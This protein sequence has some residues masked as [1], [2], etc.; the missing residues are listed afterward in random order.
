MAIVC[1]LVSMSDSLFSNLSYSEAWTVS[2]APLDLHDPRILAMAAAERH[3]LE[4]EYDEYADTNAS[5]AA[6]CRSAAL[7]VRQLLRENHLLAVLLTWKTEL[8]AYS[9]G[10]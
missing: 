9:Y 7:I 6:F 1:P 4:A 10:R 3:L 8:C 2:G 5:G